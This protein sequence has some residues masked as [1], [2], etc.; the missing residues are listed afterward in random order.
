MEN[1]VSVVRSWEKQQLP[2]YQECIRG[3]G[4]KTGEEAGAEE[5]SRTHEG[6]QE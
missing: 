4:Q 2:K 3:T 5:V 6:D 1:G